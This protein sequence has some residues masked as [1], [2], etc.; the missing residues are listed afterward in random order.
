MYKRQLLRAAHADHRPYDVVVLAASSD[1]GLLYR[2]DRIL[3]AVAAASPLSAL[4]VDEAWTAV[5][6]FHPGLRR[7]ATLPAAQRL[8]A[9]CRD[10]GQRVPAVLVTQ[11]ADKTL[12]A[13]RQTAYLHVVGG[14]DRVRQVQQA[15]FEH[16]TPSPSWPL[17]VSLDLARA[18][19]QECG[20]RELDRVL[21]L[22]DQVRAALAGDPLLAEFRPPGAGEEPGDP[23]EPHCLA[24]PLRI[25]IAVPER[26]G[27]KVLWETLFR[28]HGVYLGRGT[29]R[30]LRLSFHLGVTA[31][32]VRRLLA[33]LR[34]VARRWL[35]RPEPA[36]VP[37]AGAG[38]EDFFIPYPPGIP[39]AV[40][41]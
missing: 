26:V 37:T 20:R 15:V 1:D 4:V 32:H 21:A 7:H 14:S 17:L 34:A 10:T 33:A 22:A 40:P 11:A 23:A 25:A 24:D 30:S 5:H 29:G 27:D 38:V 18:H 6:A 16:H 31:E 19:A 9:R 2:M 41:G 36:G 13:A 12:C 39:T 28:D 35:T 8:A 3:P